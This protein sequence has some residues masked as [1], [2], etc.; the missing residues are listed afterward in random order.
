MRPTERLLQTLGGWAGGQSLRR[1][2]GE[3]CLFNIH[4]FIHTIFCVYRGKV[5]DGVFFLFWGNNS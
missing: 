2:R 3:D 4:S 1:L 5:F